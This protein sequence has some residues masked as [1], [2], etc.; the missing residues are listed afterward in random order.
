MCKCTACKI[1]LK[2]IHVF[3]PQ[4]F[5]NTPNIKFPVNE[6]IDN[7]D[8]IQDSSSIESLPVVNGVSSDLSNGKAN[9]TH[10]TPQPYP[11]T[12]KFARN[13]RK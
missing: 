7:I 2:S 8:P 3:A 4:K 6:P 13:S 1:P 11:S 5:T 12:G 9:E 10:P